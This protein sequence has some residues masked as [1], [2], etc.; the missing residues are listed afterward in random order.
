LDKAAARLTEILEHVQEN[1]ALLGSIAAQSREQAVAIEQVSHAV[2]AIDEITQQ[3]AALVEQTNAAI[4]QTEAQASELDRI[5]EV[6]RTGE[7]DPVW[8]H[9]QPASALPG[10]P[11]ASDVTLLNKRIV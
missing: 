8:V 3:N 2:R 5:V 4:E 1:S 9:P 6:F 10:P 11:R 7:G